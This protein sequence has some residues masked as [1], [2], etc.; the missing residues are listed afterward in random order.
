VP[1]PTAAPIFQDLLLEFWKR[2]DDDDREFRTNMKLD[3][4]IVR[5]ITI[6]TPAARA[7]A[8]R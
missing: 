5:E 3:C 2:A 1:D 4:T 8:Y 7:D 6:M